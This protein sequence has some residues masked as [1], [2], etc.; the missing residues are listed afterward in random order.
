[1]TIRKICDLCDELIEL[2]MWYFHQ[3]VHLETGWL[4]SHYYERKYGR[5]AQ[6]VRNE[7]RG[8]GSDEIH[9]PD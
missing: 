4:D 3:I 6:T 2:E 8:Q 7:A 1:M 5:N 9:R